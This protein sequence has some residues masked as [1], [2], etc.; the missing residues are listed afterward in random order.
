MDAKVASSIAG[1]ALHTSWRTSPANSISSVKICIVPATWH[2]ER[3]W[4]VRRAC[5]VAP[6]GVWRE[7]GM[8][9]GSKGQ[10]SG[11]SACRRYRR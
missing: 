1:H 6:R 11:R 4:G 2:R 3:R 5:H 9:R 10:C 7:E 8:P